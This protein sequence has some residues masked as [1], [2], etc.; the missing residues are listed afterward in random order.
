MNNLYVNSLVLL[1]IKLLVL[2]LIYLNRKKINEINIFLKI[3][4]IFILIVSPYIINSF[5]FGKSK[6]MKGLFYQI[7]LA[8][9]DFYLIILALFFCLV[10]YFVRKK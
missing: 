4:L 8:Y 6:D 1:I 3:I 9:S 10:Y 5:L 7:C 2:L